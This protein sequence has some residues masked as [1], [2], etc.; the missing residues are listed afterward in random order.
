MINDVKTYTQNWNAVI[1]V[2][3]K[4]KTTS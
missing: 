3:L 2:Q 4:L 1:H